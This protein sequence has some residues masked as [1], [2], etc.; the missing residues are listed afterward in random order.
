MIH[1]MPIFITVREKLDGL[2]KLLVESNPIPGTPITFKPAR[3]FPLIFAANMLEA[4]FLLE[5]LDARGLIRLVKNVGYSDVTAD[6]YERLEKIEASSYKSSGNAFVAMWFD[7]SRDP[8]YKDAIEPAIR[9]AGYKPLRIDKTEHVNRIDDEIIAELR[10]C[11]FQ[12]ADFTGQRA[13]VYFEAG[14]MLGLGRNVYWMCEN[15][16]LANVHF[17]TRQYNFI[18]YESVKDAKRRLYNRIMA[19]E[20]RGPVKPVS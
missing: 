7:K 4:K 5:Q 19:I 1:D 14:F 13:G 11:R 18:D 20:G 2:L 6:G 8:I 10:Q 17:D 9:E 12:V 3:D 15:S 16:E